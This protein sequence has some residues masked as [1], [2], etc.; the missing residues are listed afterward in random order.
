MVVSL[1]LQNLK[2]AGRAFAPEAK[3]SNACG[4]QRV[5]IPYSEALEA[6]R[7]NTCICIL[8]YYISRC[9]AEA[10]TTC[11]CH[12]FVAFVASQQPSLP[13]EVSPLAPLALGE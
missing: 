4:N 3:F 10:R 13:S 11:F 2:H 12:A 6:Q 5:Q 8:D 9:I 1:Q 7:I